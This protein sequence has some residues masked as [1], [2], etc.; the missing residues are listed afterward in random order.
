MLGFI[1]YS[2]L[3]SVGSSALI[4]PREILSLPRFAR[5]FGLCMFLGCSTTTIGSLCIR[6]GFFSG[7]LVVLPEG[8]LMEIEGKAPAPLDAG[9]GASGSFNLAES[10]TPGPSSA[11]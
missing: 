2:E 3:F 8:V 9:R 10:T 6:A 7:S 11:G 5:S 1:Q 4:S